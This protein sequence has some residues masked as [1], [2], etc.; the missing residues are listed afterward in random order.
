MIVCSREITEAFLKTNLPG[1]IIKLVPRDGYCIAHLFRENLL[2]I[3]CKVTFDDLTTC[4]R[5]E[6]QSKKYQIFKTDDINIVNELE[7]Y[8]E[9]LLSQYD[10]AIT[11]L[12]LDAFGMAFEVNI[13]ILQSDCSKCYFFD[14]VNTSICLRTLFILSEQNHYILILLCHQIRRR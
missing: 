7:Q 8:L 1:H 2:S 13:K 10:Q 3:G 14:Q 4:L 12:F 11:D 9:D 6:L 5:N